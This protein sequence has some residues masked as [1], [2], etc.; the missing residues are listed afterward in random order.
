VNLNAFITLGLTPGNTGSPGT[1]NFTGATASLQMKD[2]TS[3]G[4][5][6]TPEIYVATQGEL[7]F[8]NTR[9]IISA[10]SSDDILVDVGTVKVT[11]SVTVA[12]GIEVIDGSLTVSTGNTLSITNHHQYSGANQTDA[13]FVKTTG[14]VTLTGTAEIDADD[15]LEF[16]GS[17][18]FAAKDT[19]ADATST[20]HFTNNGGQLQIRGSSTVGAYGTNN[21]KSETL[22]VTGT[23]STVYVT[24]SATV[25][26]GESTVSGNT[27]WGYLSCVNLDFESTNTVINLYGNGAPNDHA[28][29]EMIVASG[30]L[31]NSNYPT[32]TLGVWQSWTTYGWSG[33]AFDVTY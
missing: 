30:T 17:S 23:L 25:A 22:S 5:A 24:D 7:D 33:N 13:L 15:D 31:T 20:V 12:A 3:G 1:L 21:Q 9:G 18:S 2:N 29:R 4:V 11:A 16:I 14:S 28:S 19:T 6:Y 32:I 8:N 27:G 26:V 10:D